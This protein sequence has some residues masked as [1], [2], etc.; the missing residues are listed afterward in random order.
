MA[1]ETAAI[2]EKEKKLNSEKAFSSNL[3]GTNEPSLISQNGSWLSNFQV[4][5]QEE[6]TSSFRDDDS[7]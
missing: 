5:L 3:K 4:Y 6:I 2:L 1:L 7:K